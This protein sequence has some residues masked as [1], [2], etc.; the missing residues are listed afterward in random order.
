VILLFS[1][2]ENDRLSP[3]CTLSNFSSKVVWAFKPLLYLSAFIEQHRMDYYDLLTAV[4]TRGDWLEWV[5]FFLTG[6]TE[7]ARSAIRQADAVLA[8]RS[9]LHAKLE[10]KH[11]ARALLDEL[12]INP[13][14]TIQRAAERLKV[15]D[16]TADKSV[17]LLATMKILA[18]ATGRSWGRVWVA[19]PILRVLEN[20]PPEPR[21]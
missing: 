9:H 10:G 2:T 6:V 19:R 11:R 21:Q 1:R 5:R 4:R 8:L 16:T 18:E 7:S 17:K 12:F 14:I 3:W 20:P 15:S 13:Y